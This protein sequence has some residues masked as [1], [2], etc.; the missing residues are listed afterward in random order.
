MIDLAIGGPDRSAVASG[1]RFAQARAGYELRIGGILWMI[2]FVTFSLAITRQSLWTDEGFTVWF[3][4]HKTIASFFTALI[5][6]PGTP[7]DPQML[8]YLLY[9]WGWIKLCGASELALRLANIPFAILLI[10]TIGWASR[11][12]LSQPWSRLFFCL[13]PFFWFYLNEARP[14]VALMAFATAAI[15]ALL[16]YLIY[17]DQYGEFAPWICLI[18]LLL[19]WGTHIMAAFLF[20]S[21]MITAALTVAQEPNLRRKFLRDWAGPTFCC[22][23]AFV[24]LGTFYI[25]ASSYGVNKFDSTNGV[26][27]LVYIGYEFAGFGGLGPPRDEIRQNP[28][29]IAFIPYW[30]WLLLGALALLGVGYSVLRVRPPKIVQNLLLSLLFGVAIAFLL[31]KFAQFRVVGRHLAVFFPLV[32]IALM[33]WVNRAISS[34]TSRVESIFALAALALVWGISDARL[35]FL[36]KYEKDS[37]RDASAIALEIAHLDGGKILWAA[38]RHTARYYGIRV[39]EGNVPTGMEQDDGTE[40]PVKA[41]AIDAVNWN[42]KAAAAYLKSTTAPVILVL[43]K[44]DTFDRKGAWRA[45]IEQRA[46]LEIARLKAF[47][48]YEWRP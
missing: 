4:S 25:W 35:V 37:Y 15:V 26:S 16:A 39:V 30:P 10:G 48:I 14:Y 36:S 43:S 7:G 8:F 19:A 40:W 18:T 27:N 42:P 20:P 9:M 28:H 5:G 38:D 1:D 41:Q 11:F 44:A 45:L 13:S 2:L 22:L 12:L 29:L 23:P 17:P 33:F 46:P 34:R 47:S 24:A 32:F 3:A 31:A 6:S 21:L